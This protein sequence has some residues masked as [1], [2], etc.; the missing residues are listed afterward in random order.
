VQAVE[1][2]GRMGRGDNLELLADV[3]EGEL[4]LPASTC[5]ARIRWL[6]ASKS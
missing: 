1:E 6:R 4:V 5:Q 2:V 3:V